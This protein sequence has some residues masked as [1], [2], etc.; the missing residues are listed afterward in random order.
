MIISNETENDI[1]IVK[2][3][4]EIGKEEEQSIRDHFE[5]IFKRNIKK[6]IIDASNIQ[7][8]GSSTLGLFSKIHQQA[9]T[10]GARMIFADLSPFV[11]KIFKITTFDKYFIIKYSIKDAADDLN[12]I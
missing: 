3:D 9:A 4:G 8:L 10:N 6:V 12:K 1:L 2:I 5:D 11:K 7:Y